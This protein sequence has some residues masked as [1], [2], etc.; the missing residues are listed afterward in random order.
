MRECLYSLSSL[1][2]ILDSDKCLR[3]LDDFRADNLKELSY[4]HQTEL[5]GS[6]ATMCLT[7]KGLTNHYV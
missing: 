3:F 4:D 1:R 7:F 6:L 5:V 2:E